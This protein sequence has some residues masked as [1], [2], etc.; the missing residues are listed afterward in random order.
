MGEKW[1]TINRFRLIIL[2]I[3]QKLLYC[4]FLKI[5]QESEFL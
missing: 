5:K 1:K 3:T 2:D 4:F